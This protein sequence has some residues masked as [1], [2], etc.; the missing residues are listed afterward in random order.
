MSGS[1]ERV[2]E[3]GRDMRAAA[4]A[5][6]FGRVA[7][8]ESERLELLSKLPLPAA[9]QRGL[10]LEIVENDRRVVALTVA[11]HREAAATLQQQR[12]ATAQIAAYSGTSRIAL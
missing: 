4:E 7:D 8:Y 2:L 9:N 12:R 6:L 3:L 11:A 1:W 10:L 5:G